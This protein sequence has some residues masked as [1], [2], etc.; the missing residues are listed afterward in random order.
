ML[1]KLPEIRKQNLVLTVGGYKEAIRTLA[2][3]VVVLAEDGTPTRTFGPSDYM[4]RSNAHAVQFR[5]R[6]SEHFIL[7]ETDPAMVGDAVS[8]L[9]QQLTQSQNNVYTG[10]TYTGTYSTYS[11]HERSSR[12]VYS[13]EGVILVRLQAIDGHIGIAE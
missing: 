12:R 9:Q 8:S 1:F 7:V 11:G 6:E 2:G 10:G 4:S 5:P 13:H 3:R